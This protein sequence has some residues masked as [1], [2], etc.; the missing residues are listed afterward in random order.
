MVIFK[1]QDVESFSAE[2]YSEPLRIT[3]AFFVKLYIMI[4][5]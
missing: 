2:L 4:I 1:V 3:M 5:K